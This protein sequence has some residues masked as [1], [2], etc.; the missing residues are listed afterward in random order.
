M[1]NLQREIDKLGGRQ[2]GEVQA[3]VGMEMYGTFRKE[4]QGQGIQLQRVDQNYKSPKC[5]ALDILR[6]SSENNP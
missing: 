1:D 2:D 4:G 3:P 5:L 6:K